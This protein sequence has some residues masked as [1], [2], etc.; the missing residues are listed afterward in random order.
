MDTSLQ[1]PLNLMSLHALRENIH[2]ALVAFKEI[3]ILCL[4]HTM[5]KFGKQVQ[6]SCASPFIGPETLYK[7]GAKQ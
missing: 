6:D 7:P 2:R 4:A 5:T 1:N 3:G